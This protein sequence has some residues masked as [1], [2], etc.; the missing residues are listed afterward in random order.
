MYVGFFAP[1]Y[2]CCSSI[3]TGGLELN[4]G[5]PNESGHY[6]TLKPSNSFVVDKLK[7][8]GLNVLDNLACFK[9]NMRKLFFII[10]L[11][12][13]VMLIGFCFLF[14][15]DK[16]KPRMG[17]GKDLGY[18]YR[19]KS[20]V[21]YVSFNDGSDGRSIYTVKIDGADPATFRALS[22]EYSNDKNNVYFFTNG[23][24][25]LVKQADP[26]T[27]GLFEDYPDNWIYFFAR[28]SKH[29]YKSGEI[30]DGADL[31]TFQI[32]KKGYSKDKNFIYTGSSKIEG[33]DPGTFLVLNSVYSK[34]KNNVYYQQRVL[35]N[36]NP[37]TFEI[38]CE[39]K[40]RDKNNFY[41]GN[42]IVKS[43]EPCNQ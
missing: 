15:I 32:L 10:Q 12:V 34:D 21:V 9:K 4:P 8:A 11:I 3:G 24:V 1:L 40:A 2:F 28:D 13:V 23:I 17:E 43:V 22:H 37:G 29:I 20:G 16:F 27:F 14:N 30:I 19:T 5:N 31:V 7:S 33:A 39:Q 42:Q 41:S 26:L 38:I 25:S 36:A 35:Q 6:Q 18:G